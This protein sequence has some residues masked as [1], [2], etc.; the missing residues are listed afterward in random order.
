MTFRPAAI[1]ILFLL[2]ALNPVA[3]AAAEEID[4]NGVPFIYGT[5]FPTSTRVN[6]GQSKFIDKFGF[7]RY[8]QNSASV[9]DLFVPFQSAEEWRSFREF[10][11]EGTALNLCCAPATI[12]YCGETRTISS[13]GTIGSV[14]TLNFG[15]SKS[16]VFSC[17]GPTP[18]VDANGSWQSIS[19]SGECEEP[20][21]PPSNSSY[22]ESDGPSGGG[23]DSGGGSSGGSDC[24]GEAGGSCSI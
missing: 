12:S 20:P 6:A 10:N 9:G 11:P 13:V 14:S 1:A 17:S 7:C 2:A 5:N 23:T 24:G 3:K 8:V 18:T 21:P 4:M 16:V 22:N 15:Y 19:E